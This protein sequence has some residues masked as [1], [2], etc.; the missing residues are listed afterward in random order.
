MKTIKGEKMLTGVK[1]S[2][3]VSKVVS[4]FAAAGEDINDLKLVSIA[5]VALKSNDIVGTGTKIN[6]G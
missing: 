5:S 6:E 2:N 4:Y 3:T 1:S